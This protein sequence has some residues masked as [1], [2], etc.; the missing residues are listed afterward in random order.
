MKMVTRMEGRFKYD[1]T[2]TGDRHATVIPQSKICQVWLCHLP[3][4]A[5]FAPKRNVKG[6]PEE[7]FLGPL[8]HGFQMSCSTPVAYC[9]R[10]WQAKELAHTASKGSGV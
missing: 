5:N 7:D 9:S 6:P 8:G 2:M 10:T 4:A 3:G 1:L